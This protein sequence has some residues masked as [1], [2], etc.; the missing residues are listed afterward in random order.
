MYLVSQYRSGALGP[1]NYQEF[2]THTRA[3][4][5]FSEWVH[6]GLNHG[7]F[8]DETGNDWVLLVKGSQYKR[9]EIMEV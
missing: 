3:K 2:V 4:L 9:I 1:E 6:Q 8:I 5:Q 7:W